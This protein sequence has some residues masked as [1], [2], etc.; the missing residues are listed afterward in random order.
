MNYFANTRYALLLALPTLAGCNVPV[1]ES[2]NAGDALAYS[3]RYTVT[4]SRGSDEVDVSMRVGQNRALLR[5]V[6]FPRNPAISDLRVD[7]KEVAL[8]DEITWQPPAS[9]GTLQWKAKLAHQRGNSHFDALLTEEWG[10]FR[11]EDLIP[12]AAT[13]V[14]KGAYS[15]TVIE[16]DLPK[17][18]SVVTPY[19]ESDD[20]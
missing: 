1:T 14:I 20:R 7:G 9:G 10:I 8:S 13:R 15:K 19:E 17:N 6:R 4:I 11:A 3:V 5:E 12:R 2:I 18:W 16:F